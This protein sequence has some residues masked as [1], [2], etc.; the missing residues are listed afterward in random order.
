MGTITISVDAGASG[1]V[2]KTFTISNPN[3]GRL[4]G[5]MKDRRPLV[6]GPPGAAAP[7]PMTNAEAFELWIESV[8]GEAR[9]TVVAAERTKA[10]VPDFAVS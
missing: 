3:L 4:A 1:S 8:M 5:V 10:V 7:D 6:P 2:S 9:Q